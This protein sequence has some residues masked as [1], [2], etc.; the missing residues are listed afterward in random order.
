MYKMEQISKEAYKKYE[1][2]IIDKGKYFWI[3][4]RD[5]AEADI[6][7][8]AQIF[9]KCDPEKQ[10]YRHKLMPNTTFQPSRKFVG[11]DLA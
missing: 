6:A 3:N 7:N 11:N 10:K 2:E 9:D 5:I 8:W 1:V 4:R